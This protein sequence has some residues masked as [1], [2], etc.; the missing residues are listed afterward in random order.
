MYA[1]A[2]D[3]KVADLELHYPGNSHSNAYVDIK[4]FLAKEGFSRQQGSVYFG[5]PDKVDMVKC[6]LAVNKL[7]RDFAWFKE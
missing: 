4:K 1:I 5:D 7:S 2:F 3:L 6:V